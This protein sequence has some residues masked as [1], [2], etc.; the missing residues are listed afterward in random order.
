VKPTEATLFADA[1]ITVKFLLLAAQCQNDMCADKET[2][3]KLNGMKAKA[4]INCNSEYG[5][6]DTAKFA[7]CK[8]AVNRYGKFT[9]GK[10]A[11]GIR[12]ESKPEA[13]RER[14]A[15]GLDLRG[16][17]EPSGV[18][19]V[20]VEFY[21]TWCKPCIA[22]VPEWKKLQEKY[23]DLGLRLVVVNTQ[24][25]DGNTKPLGWMPD[26]RVFDPEGTIAQAVGVG[27][28]LPTAL[29]WSWQGN[30]LVDRGHITEV[31]SAIEAY[32]RQ[33]PRVL[34]TAED[35]SG[36]PDETLRDALR[37]KLHELGKLIV[38]AT[39]KEKAELKR[40][41]LDSAKLDK[42]AALQCEMGKEISANSLLKAKVTGG[43]LYLTLFSAE[44]SC[45]IASVSAHYAPSRQ[46]QTVAEVIGYL[47]AKIRR[48][49]IQMPLAG[50]H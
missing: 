39:D 29:L 48:G 42:E 47:M 23:H 24:D 38:V 16:Y 46:Q 12:A 50:G 9:V 27:N 34:V 25:F 49:S 13:A 8:A 6:T 17:I 26:H 2:A 7:E 31:A 32:L 11:A 36:R 22:A 3:K 10:A 30:L 15:D 43:R 33:N 14:V 28:A 41:Q 4:L 35:E 40:I 5:L 20:A 19:L 21:A 44:R 37:A 45:A 1:K 18:R